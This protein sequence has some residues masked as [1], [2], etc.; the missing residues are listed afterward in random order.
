[1]LTLPA[2]TPPLGAPCGL[3]HERRG[4]RMPRALPCHASR[5]LFEAV[6]TILP[7]VATTSCSAVSSVSC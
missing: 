5:C 7:T 6:L 4:A 3:S 2:L 1:M